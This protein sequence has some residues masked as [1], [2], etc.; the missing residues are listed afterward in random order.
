MAESFPCLICGCPLERAFDGFEAQPND[1]VMCETSGNYGSTV[2]DPMDLSELA[3]NIC[4]DCL[5]EKAEQGRVMVTRY[6]RPVNVDAMHGVGRQRVQS[7]VF[8]PWHKGLP[9][10]GSEVNLD[11]E[12]L[13]KLPD[14]IELRFTAQEIK[15][16]L[17]DW[18]KRRLQRNQP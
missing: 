3:F 2:F 10:D 5:V 11:E 13:D 15:D 7:P 14:S 4:D 16:Y 12:D 1:G 8:I 17:A 18:D 9:Y 6:Y